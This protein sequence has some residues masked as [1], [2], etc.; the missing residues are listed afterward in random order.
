VQFQSEKQL[1]AQVEYYAEWPSRCAAM[2][3]YYAMKAYHANAGEFT[4]D[5]GAL[6]KYTKPPFELFEDAH[7]VAINLTANGYEVSVTIASHTATVNEDRY[8]VVVTKSGAA[9]QI[10]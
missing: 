1:N 2:A 3:I 5:M 8:L 6:K 9:S 7:D 4:T 10:M